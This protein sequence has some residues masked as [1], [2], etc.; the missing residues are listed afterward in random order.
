VGGFVWRA[1]R[2]RSGSSHAR[3]A[4]PP[5][6]CAE[7]AGGIALELELDDTLPALLVDPRRLKQIAFNLLSNAVKFTGPAGRVTLRA[8]RVN[9]DEL[10]GALSGPNVPYP[11][12]LEIAVCDTGIGIPREAL[13]KLFRPFM[14]VESS[15]SRKFQGTGLGLALVKHLADLHGGTVGV[16]SAPGEGS[17][18]FVWL[19]YRAVPV[20]A[21]GEAP[22]P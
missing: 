6:E 18:F 19:P 12:F 14:Q 4:A 3:I 10:R 5:A 1:S 22:R 9:Y 21:A 8:R 11:A 17:T 15:A 2:G 20:N 7:P 13:P 16:E